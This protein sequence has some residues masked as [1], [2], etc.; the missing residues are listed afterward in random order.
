MACVQ[1]DVYGFAPWKEAGPGQAEER[2]HY[3]DSARPRP[4][5]H[6]FDLATYIYQ[7]MATQHDHVHIHS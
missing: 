4:G 6:S 1:V 5:S 2:Y 3:F 7:L